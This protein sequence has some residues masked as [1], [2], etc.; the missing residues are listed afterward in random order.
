[1]TLLKTGLR[2]LLRRPLLSLLCI[3]GVALGVAVV[4]AIDLAND[5][6]S[7]AFNLST[8]GRRRPGHPSDRG[9]Q[10]TGR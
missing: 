7:R 8:G 5:S 2:H 6:A 3:L 10:R 1:M 4:I 9:R